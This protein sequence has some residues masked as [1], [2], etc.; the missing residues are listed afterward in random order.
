MEVGCIYEEE[1]V[2]VDDSHAIILR[3]SVSQ[4]S[5]TAKENHPQTISL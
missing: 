4:D 5:T 3:L 1:Q 2:V